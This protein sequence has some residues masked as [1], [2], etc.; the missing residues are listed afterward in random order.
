MVPAASFLCLLHQRM[1]MLIM[2]GVHDNSC[3]SLRRKLT[4][5]RK[6]E[7]SGRNFPCNCVCATLKHKTKPGPQS[8]RNF[9]R[10]LVVGEVEVFSGE[11]SVFFLF[12][13]LRSYL[14]QPNGMS[15]A[16]TYVCIYIYVLVYI[17]RVKEVNGTAYY[18]RYC[19]GA[20]LGFSCMTA[21]SS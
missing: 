4:V 5:R 19:K 6:N 12:S 18:C 14:M 2:I 20:G 3:V 10:T 21:H 13:W 9:A 1:P 11:H 17:Y 15:L 7:I 16:S 8:D